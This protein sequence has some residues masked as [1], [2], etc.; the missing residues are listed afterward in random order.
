MLK[1]IVFLL[2]WTGPD[3]THAYKVTFNRTCARTVIDIVSRYLQP[4]L[5]H[6][7]KAKKLTRLI[8]Y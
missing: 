6:V 3:S 4:A 8:K 2:D 1:N 5:M 7:G